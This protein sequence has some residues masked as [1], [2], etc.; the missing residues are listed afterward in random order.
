VGIE[1]LIGACRL[2][3]GISCAA[4]GYCFSLACCV[5]QVYEHEEN[6]CRGSNRGVQMQGAVL[7]A[8]RCETAVE[9]TGGLLPQQWSAASEIRSDASA[10]HD[11]GK[12]LFGLDWAGVI[13]QLARAWL[14]LTEHLYAV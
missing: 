3:P 14:R 11:S 4:F 9:V 6:Q 13:M 2:F 8:A 1:I 5:V 12:A 7:R 10:V